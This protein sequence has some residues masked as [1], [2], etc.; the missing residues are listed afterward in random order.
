MNETIYLASYPKSGNTWFRTF[1]SNLLHEDERDINSID[2][3]GIASGR[4]PFDEMLGINS[5]DLDFEEID[6]LRPLVYKRI[7]GCAT[8][9]KFLKVHD[10]YTMT[11]DGTPLFPS[12]NSKAIY[13]VRNPLDVSVSFSYH[14]SV[15][16]DR[17]IENMGKGDF[18]FC[19]NDNRLHKQ[20]RQQL[21]S[22]SLHVSSWMNAKDMEVYFMRYED[23][24]LNPFE[25]FK[26][27]V[28]FIGMDVTKEQ[29]I[30]A[31]GLSDFN[32]LKKQE[33]EKGFKEKPV[34][35]ESF[36]RKGQ[37]GDWKNHLNQDQVKRI[38]EDHGHMMLKLGY[39]K[40]NGEI[41]Y[42]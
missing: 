40:D 25:T 5:S 26:K 37:I 14:L 29:I 16:I 19:G 36:F 33:E 17:A 18:S 22:W 21:L 41:V 13:I 2:T 4:K 39:T 30:K 7:S 27:A 12:E 31:I 34:G 32:R 42:K 8:K 23:M 6:R 20:L 24:K 28:D 10:A 38:I 3:D 35:M 9:R 15:D 1:I 11:N